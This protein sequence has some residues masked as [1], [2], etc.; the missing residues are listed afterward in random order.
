MI[1]RRNHRTHSW[2]RRDRRALVQRATNHEECAW[3]GE[4][5]GRLREAS[6]MFGDAV[7][8]EICDSCVDRE[9]QVREAEPGRYHGSDFEE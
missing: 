3:C 5:A 7:C 2:S 6:E 9:H 1:R 8:G 4:L